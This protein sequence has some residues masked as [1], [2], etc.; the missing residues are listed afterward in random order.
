MRSGDI[1]QML[2]R[3]PKITAA[4]LKPG[5]AIVISG[6]ATGTDSS[7][8]QASTVIAG[9]EPILQSAPQRQSGQSLG[10]DWG[11]GEMSAPQ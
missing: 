6:V 3:L 2:D 5:D 4:D 1:S 8:L 11:L 9:V 7:R 10:G